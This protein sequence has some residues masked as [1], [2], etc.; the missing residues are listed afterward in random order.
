MN[1]KNSFKIV[2]SILVILTALLSWKLFAILNSYL[3]GWRSVLPESI[4]LN[5]IILFFLYLA[6]PLIT[7]LV[8]FR[9][10]VFTVLGLDQNILKAFIF[11]VLC[12]LP[13]F[14]AFLFLYPLDP[15]LSFN[16]VWLY[17]IR[18][19]LWEELIFRAFLFGLLFRFYGW[20]F[21]PAAL[22]SS[23]FFGIGHI[24]QGN[25]FWTS[26]FSFL[27]TALGSAWFAWLYLEWRKNIWV[28]VFFHLLLNLAWVL[29]D[30]NTGAIGNFNSNIFR[31]IA[32]VL[33]IV[34]T[35]RYGKSRERT[36]NEKSL[37]QST[38]EL[39]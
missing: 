15:E 36:V 25:D 22:I 7:T 13:V 2:P 1:A 8:L 31:A 16:S 38:P 5:N 34:I 30:V 10:K 39:F 35:V 27:V 14:I 20:G 12:T 32:I 19:A 26:T 33:S 3:P 21:I 18:P 6:V 29:F 24:Y 9:T 23:L 28:P 37:W 17:S 4:F 11:S